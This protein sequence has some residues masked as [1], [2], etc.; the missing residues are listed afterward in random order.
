MRL[1]LCLCLMLVATL[2][3]VAQDATPE[4]VQPLTVEVQAEDELL[5]RGDFYALD[6]ESP[7]VL[8]M[9][10]LGSER[11]AWSPLIPVLLEAGYQVLA[12]D[13]RGHGETDGTLDWTAAQSDVAVWLAWLREQPTVRDNAISLIGA[14]VGSSL[15]LVGCSN[16]EQCVTAILLSPVDFQ[17]IEEEAA[18][19]GL[20][21]RSMLLVT[22]R[23]DR[24]SYQ[25]TL[26]LIEESRAE[27]SSLFYP[28]GSHGTDLLGNSR[29]S[30]RLITS[31][32]VWL[33]TH[34]PQP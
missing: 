33:D 11:R 8:L 30:E 20:Q 5:L 18:L 4:A 13:L 24:L 1:M 26:L 25:Q 15:A 7:T 10:M 9:H 28:T 27:I 31:M 21:T 2:P 29:I 3:L 23:T 17:I 22:G 14:S 16:D 6:F 34:T 19:D 32:I 12:V